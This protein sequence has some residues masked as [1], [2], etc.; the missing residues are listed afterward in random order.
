MGVLCR[1]HVFVRLCISEM[2]R[3]SIIIRLAESLG[4][5]SLAGLVLALINTNASASL[6]EAHVRYNVGFILNVNAKHLHK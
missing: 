1:K 4:V 6:V 3:K 5:V 2:V